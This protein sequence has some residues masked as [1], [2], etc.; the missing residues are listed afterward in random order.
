MLL[1]TPWEKAYC[2]AMCAAMC[3]DDVDDVDDGDKG[4]FCVNV[5][6]SNWM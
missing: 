6:W 5:G 2:L 4:I 3:D 1:V